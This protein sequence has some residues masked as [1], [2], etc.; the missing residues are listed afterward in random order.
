MPTTPLET[1]SLDILSNVRVALANALAS[2]TTEE[3]PDHDANHDLRVALRRLREELRVFSP[4]LKKSRTKKLS[5]SLRRGRDVLA[6]LRDDEVLIARID[7]ML[8]I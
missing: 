7:S 2:A 6:D 5:R 1:L 8:P 4:L 3:S